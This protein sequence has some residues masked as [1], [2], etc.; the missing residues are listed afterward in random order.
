M[1]NKNY[2]NTTGFMEYLE[3]NF[4]GFANSF[5]R[6]MVEK[7]VWYALNF[8]ND[9]KDGVCNFLRDILP[10]EVDLWEIAVFADDSILTTETLAEKKMHI[11]T[12]CGEIIAEDEMTIVNEEC[13][14]RLILCDI[15]HAV[16]CEEG[17]ITFC[18][19]CGKYYSI[20][21]LKGDDDGFT[22]CPHCGHDIIEG[23]TKEEYENE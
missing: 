3:K 16:R 8:R 14:P 10:D 23:T 19:N 5:L 22:P 7:A 20:D 17:S 11:C 2:F 4:T 15:C 1:V 13:G 18:T 21:V 6:E 9:S 12:D